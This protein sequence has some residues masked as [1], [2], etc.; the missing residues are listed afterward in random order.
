MNFNFFPNYYFLV[1]FP[2]DYFGDQVPRDIADLCY[3]LKDYCDFD[4]KQFTGFTLKKKG[5]FTIGKA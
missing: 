5:A 3:I 4:M 2:L 1:F